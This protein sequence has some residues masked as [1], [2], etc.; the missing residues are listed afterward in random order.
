M[1]PPLVDLYGK[2][3]KNPMDSNSPLLKSRFP[4]SE[5][6]LDGDFLLRKSH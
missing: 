5:K 2:G 1:N 3:A 6:P 4:T